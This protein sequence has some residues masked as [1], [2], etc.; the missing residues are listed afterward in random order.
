MKV[1]NSTAPSVSVLDFE[2]ENA[3][4]HPVAEGNVSKSQSTRSATW[5]HVIVRPLV[6]QYRLNDPAMNNNILTV[7]VSV[8]HRAIWIY[9]TP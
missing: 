8:F 6:W 5:V 2:F 7:L 1:L 4:R 9:E 3:T